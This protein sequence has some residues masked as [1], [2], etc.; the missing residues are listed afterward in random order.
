M[1]ND[2]RF[3]VVKF[4]DLVDYHDDR[5]RVISSLMSYTDSLS[6]VIQ[7]LNVH[8]PKYD[9]P[10][11]ILDYETNNLIFSIPEGIEK[12]KFYVAIISDT[13]ESDEINSDSDE[14]LNE[15]KND[16]MFSE[17]YDDDYTSPDCL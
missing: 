15:L 12:E 8:L 11:V 4:Y 1:S 10:K 13:D 6:F 17:E 2:I 9:K 14:L 3:Y 7:M 5:V 16:L